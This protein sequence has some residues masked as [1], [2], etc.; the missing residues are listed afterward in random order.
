MLGSSPR[1]RAAAA[2]AARFGSPS[3]RSTD[4]D[5]VVDGLLREEEPVGELGVGESVGEQ[6]EHLELARGEAGRVGSGLLR[7][8]RAGPP[9][10]PASASQQRAAGLDG[11]Q[12][13]RAAR[14]PSARRRRTR[15][16]TGRAPCHQRAA[17][18]LPRRRGPDPVAVGHPRER[19]GDAG[20]RGRVEPGGPRATSPASASSQRRELV[21][22]ERVERR[23]APGGRRRGRRSVQA[24]SARATAT[25][26]IRWTSPVSAARSRAWSSRSSASGRSPRRRATV[27][28]TTRAGMRLTGGTFGLRITASAS[29]AAGAYRPC[30]SIEVASHAVMYRSQASRSRSAQ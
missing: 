19:V 8:A 7:G 15:R 18:P 28:A 12:A 26:R 16:A 21:G 29:C 30:S 3:L 14:C 17:D 10:R 9:A 11:A 22:G 23:R 5:V 27:P 24:A 4:G 6:A 20:P 13:R 25:G 2:A 1:C